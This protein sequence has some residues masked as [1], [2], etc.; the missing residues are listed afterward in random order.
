MNQNNIVVNTPD[1]PHPK[2]QIHTVNLDEGRVRFSW[3]DAGGNPVD[4]GNSLA[5]LGAITS[6]PTEAD[7][8]AAITAS[9]D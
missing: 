3:R 4:S 1:A 6:L 2:A 5:Q 9:T 7:L 8:V